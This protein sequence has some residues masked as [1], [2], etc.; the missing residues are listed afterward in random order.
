[1]QPVSLYQNMTEEIISKDFLQAKLDALK[2]TV[3]RN[4]WKYYHIES[5]Q[6]FIYHLNSFSTERT[7]NRMAGKINAYLSSL[8][9]KLKKNM[10]H[11]G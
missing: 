10:M 7:Q 6:N 1:M 8:E 9:E 11:I 3:E 5:V 4:Q 2:S